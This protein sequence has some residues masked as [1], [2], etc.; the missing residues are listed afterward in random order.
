MSGTSLFSS[1]ISLSVVRYLVTTP[2]TLKRTWPLI[3]PENAPAKYC[4]DDMRP[5]LEGRRREDFDTRIRTQRPICES[6]TSASIP[7]VRGP[8]LI[9]HFSNYSLCV[10]VCIRMKWC[11]PKHKHLSSQSQLWVV[12][13]VCARTE[14]LVY[15]SD[16]SAIS[17]EFIRLSFSSLA[18]Y[19]AS[20]II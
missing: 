10:C 20:D 13:S 16:V 7:L 9:W 8:N 5:P 18:Q 11:C 3:D 14:W 19:L 6:T 4:P 12:A 17:V 2:S 1:S 15:N